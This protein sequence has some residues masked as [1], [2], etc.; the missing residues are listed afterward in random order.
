MLQ[1]TETFPAGFSNI[2]NLSSCTGLK[3][4]RLD[5]DGS[6]KYGDRDINGGHVPL[7]LAQLQAPGLEEIHFDFCE[8]P[9]FGFV[10]TTPSIVWRAIAR[11]LSQPKFASLRLLRI[12]LFN[13]NRYEEGIVWFG[14]VFNDYLEQ[15]KIRFVQCDW[16]VLPS[17]T[18]KTFSL[19]FMCY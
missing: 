1:V 6:L 7:L 4:I 16:Y 17:S 8:R 18:A 11:E 19:K 9:W 2:I 5:T 13:D 12:T 15:G 3:R 14:K 10:S